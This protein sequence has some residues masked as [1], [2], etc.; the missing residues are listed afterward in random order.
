MPIGNAEHAR[1]AMKEQKRGPAD[2]VGHAAAG[3]ARQEAG[4]RVKKAQVQRGHALV[5]EVDHD[6]D[7]GG[8]DEDGRERADRTVTSRARDASE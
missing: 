6:S 5:E 7:Q 8:D 2:G 1:L 3:N 4:P